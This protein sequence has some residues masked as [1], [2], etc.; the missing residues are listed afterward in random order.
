M[1]INRYKFVSTVINRGCGPSRQ[2]WWFCEPREL[3][4]QL[5]LPNTNP[6]LSTAITSSIFPVVFRR[7]SIPYTIY[8][9]VYSTLE[10]AF[11]LELLHRHNDNYRRVAWQSPSLPNVY[12]ITHHHRRPPMNSLDPFGD[13]RTYLLIL[14]EWHSRHLKPT[15]LATLG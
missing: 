3:N 12:S 8:R 2:P 10:V 9:Y 5:A 15:A 7:V 4:I 14:G 6:S 13:P 1:F 11:S